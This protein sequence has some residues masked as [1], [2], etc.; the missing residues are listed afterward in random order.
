MTRTITACRIDGF[1]PIQPARSQFRRLT[2]AIVGVGL[3]TVGGAASAQASN[4]PG[5]FSGNAYA[6]YANVTAGPLA[7]GLGQSAYIPCPCQG[8]G[9]KVVSNSIAELAVGTGG[10]VLKLGA[11][12]SST[13][14]TKTSG[15]AEVTDTSQI[16]GVKLLGDLITADAITAVADVSATASKIT[17]S[18]AGSG[19]VNLKVAGQ[20]INVNVAPNTVISLVGLGK[21][22]LRKT[23]SSSSASSGSMK[24]EM[25]SIAVNS[26][27]SYGLPV[28]VTVVVGHALSGFNRT[29]PTA[30]VGGQAYGASANVTVGSVL[31]AKIG[32]P[33]LV[34]IPCL[35]TGGKI[36]TNNV[37]ATSVAGLLSLGAST[38]TAFGGD[39]TS[40]QTT[41]RVAR[42]TTTVAGVSLLG[43]LIGATAITSV[44]Q[45]T[46]TGSVR[47]RSTS[48]TS[49]ADLKVLGLSLP[50]HVTPNTT[51]NL[52]L[53]G[54]VVVNEQIVPTSGGKTIVNGLHITVT[55]ANLLGLP[56]GSEIVVGHADAY[57]FAFPK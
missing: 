31:R 48:G 56:V 49:F 51:I 50:V 42:T 47:S 6:S 26:A 54:K 41:V 15:T 22:T 17:P 43:G 16:T 25:I 30:V 29:Q 12:V 7:V 2:A 38:T 14:T 57:A 34:T 13:K 27:N 4:L 35:G 23:V 33:A 32:Q 18:A 1:T 40:G 21:V 8:T 55:T 44:A 52:P 45:E 20:S 24:V 39:Q 28:G 3:A 5:T 36:L 10:A 11:A 19:F 9:G 46:V 37:N 53:L